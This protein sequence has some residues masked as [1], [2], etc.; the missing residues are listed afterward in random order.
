VKIQAQWVVTSGKQTNKQTNNKPD[1]EIQV[2]SLIS[3]DKENE[4]N[5]FGRKLFSPSRNGTARPEPKRDLYE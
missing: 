4:E 5:M 1:H 2:F 3:T